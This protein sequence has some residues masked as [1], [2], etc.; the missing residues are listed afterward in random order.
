[1]TATRDFD[2]I[3]RAWLDLMPSEAPERSI[4]AVLDAVETT[5]QARPWRRG[6]WRGSPMTRLALVGAAVV[7]LIAGGLLILP[8][9]QTNVATPPSTGPSAAPPSPSAPSSATGAQFDDALRATWVAFANGSPVLGNG[10]GPVS[11]EFS[12]AGNGVSATNFGPGY[13]FPSTVAPLDGGQLEFVLARD[14]G[15]CRAG[16]RGTYLARLSADRSELVLASMSDDCRN[17]SVVFQRTWARSLLGATTVGAG[18]VDSMDPAFAVKLPDQSY[19]T[20]TLDDFAE[21]ASSSGFSL[22][23]F[24]NPQTFV[25]PCSTQEERVPYVAGADAFFDHFRT[26][27]A[28]DVGEVTEL[29]VDGHR[30]LHANVGGKSYY[31]RCPGQDLYQYTPQACN[32]HF[33]VG[34]GGTD[35]MYVVEV[36]TDSYLFI[37]SPFLS[38]DERAVI[39]S[40]RIPYQIPVQ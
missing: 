1:M 7:A 36:G 19:Q 21:I 8:R 5:P 13:D 20:R 9:L 10:S 29:Q 26:N 6:S 12:A 18:V 15:A 14:S 11:L 16:D 35:S 31:A 25:D 33:I 4:D 40:I 17:R 24:K 37:V 2:D 30:A 22:M 27:D 34:P 32:C 23:A 38:R 28:F 3:A 39:D